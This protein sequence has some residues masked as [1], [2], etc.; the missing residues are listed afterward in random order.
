MSQAVEQLLKDPRIWRIGQMPATLRPGIS[1]GYAALDAE[2]PEN[3]WPEGNVTELLCDGSGVGEVHLVTPAIREATGKGRGVVVVQAPHLP[4]PPAWRARGLD[5]ARIIFVRVEEDS[6]LWA[7]EQAARSGACG[8]VL[9]WSPKSIDYASI[10]R[11]QLASEAGNAITLLNR[12]VR[13]ANA[14]SPAPLRLIMRGH[15]GKLAI[16]L[17]KRRGALQTTEVM[18]PIF[19]EHW[20]SEYVEQVAAHTQMQSSTDAP[21]NPHVAIGTGGALADSD[22]E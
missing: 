8:V 13:A 15:L 10:R 16:T 21:M 2:L 22:D 3:G 17:I 1:T 9:V 11:L 5:L 14:P 19:P 7:A 18:L 20:Q 12:P 6:I 4:F